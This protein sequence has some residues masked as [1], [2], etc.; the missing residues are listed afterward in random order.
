MADHLTR[1]DLKRNELGEAIEAGMHY[2]EDHL[3]P[4]LLIIGA[5]AAA[6][7][8]GWGIFAWTSSRTAK[9]NELLARALKVANAEIVASGAKPDDAEAPTFT[10]EAA[11]RDR[12]RELFAELEERYGSTAVGRVGAL[13]LAEAA[14]EAGDRAEARR[15]WEAYLEDDPASA[16]AASVR[17]NLFRLDREEGKGEAL[18]ESLRKMLED[19][20]K[21]LPADL[22]LY[23]LART[24]ETLGKPGDA[25]AAY[26]RIVDEH[27]QSPYLAE[28]QR[29]AGASATPPLGS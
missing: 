3:R 6:A 19:P 22:V 21:P 16:V 1:G 13:Y 11:R 8:V 7:L 14:R 5:L 20:A 29:V 23:E 2:A 18:A 24:Y 28:A 4:I 10:T 12:A 25:R 15:L 17:V 27:P 9:A 26:R